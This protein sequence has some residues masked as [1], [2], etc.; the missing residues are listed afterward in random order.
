MEAF[1]MAKLK[2][3]TL[4]CFGSNPTKHATQKWHFTHCARACADLADWVYP[5]APHQVAPEM[6]YDLIKNQMGCTDEEVEG[7]GFE[8]PRIWFRFADGRYDGLEVSMAHIADV[9]RR[10]R[11]DGIAGYSNGAGIALLAAAA[12]EGGREAFQSIRFVMSFAGPTSPTMQRHI[13]EYLGPRRDQLTMPAIIFGS[14]HD[15]ML[16]LVDQMAADVFERCELAVT[17]EKRPC[18][19]HAL[20]DAPACY[21]SIVKFLGARQTHVAC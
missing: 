20:P 10:E 3:A 6:V 21:A 18:S 12:C 8:D 14:R 16:A 11:P 7:F 13:R 5:A 2:I 19:N 17:D 1:D 9:C 15:P 4:H